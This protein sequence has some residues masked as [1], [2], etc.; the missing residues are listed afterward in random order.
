MK[1]RTLRRCPINVLKI[2]NN[3]KALVNLILAFPYF[4][5]VK[6]MILILNPNP[7]LDILGKLVV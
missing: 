4:I 5:S 2:E 1:K 6:S 3:V 7:T